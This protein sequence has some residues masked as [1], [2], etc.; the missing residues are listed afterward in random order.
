MQ[1]FL[2][3][4]LVKSAIK[5]C[6]AKTDGKCLRYK[7][8]W[9]KLDYG[10]GQFIDSFREHMSTIVSD[11]KSDVIP[12]LGARIVNKDSRC[13]LLDCPPRRFQLCGTSPPYLNSS[14]IQMFTGRS[15]S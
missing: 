13:F 6:N 5:N 10:T 2:K 11:V 1:R 15:C 12:K 8:D 7:S 9:K 3:L 14:T 4:A